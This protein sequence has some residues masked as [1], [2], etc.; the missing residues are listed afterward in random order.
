MIRNDDVSIRVRGI[1]IYSRFQSICRIE[2]TRS[3][4][5]I[6]LHHATL[7]SAQC[8]YRQAAGLSA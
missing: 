2:G 8:R 3:L 7:K 1:T 5:R 4:E 6:Y